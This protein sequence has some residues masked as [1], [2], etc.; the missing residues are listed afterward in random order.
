MTTDTNSRFFEPQQPKASV[1]RMT[2]FEWEALGL[3]K[4]EVIPPG[5]LE[6]P[7]AYQPMQKA[8]VSRFLDETA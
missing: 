2:S 4:V 1:R 6:R 7:I 8:S 5:Q 3:G